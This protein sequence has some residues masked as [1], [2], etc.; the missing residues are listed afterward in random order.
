MLAV[1]F[2]RIRYLLEKLASF[3]NR[4]VVNNALLGNLHLRYMIIVRHFHLK[5]CDFCQQ[6]GVRRPEDIVDLSGFHLEQVSS[7]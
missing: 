6:V 3:V 7:E 4:Y 2:I 5:F 1:Q